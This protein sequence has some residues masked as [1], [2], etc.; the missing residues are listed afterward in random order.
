MESKDQKLWQLAKRRAR[1]RQHLA[2]Y[3]IVCAFLWGVWFVSGLKNGHRYED[4]PWPAWVMLGWGVG[5]SFSYTKAYVADT[6]G[7]VEKEYDK[8]KNN[9]KQ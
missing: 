4:M 7:A 3:M 2:A 6:P 1:F 5:L 9:N 8:L